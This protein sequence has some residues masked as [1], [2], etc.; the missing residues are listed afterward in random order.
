MVF[1]WILPFFLTQ[2]S[3]VVC[4]SYAPGEVCIFFFIFFMPLSLIFD[5][6]VANKKAHN[7]AQGVDSKKQQEEFKQGWIIARNYQ[8]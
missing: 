4:Q 8:E 3:T 7:K 2:R 5:K 6:N 1:F